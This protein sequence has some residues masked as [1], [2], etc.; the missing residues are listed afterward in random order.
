ML[1][2]GTITAYS[3]LRFRL[4]GVSPR[5]VGLESWTLT[6]VGFESGF[7]RTWTW[8]RTMRTWLQ[9]WFSLPS[10]WGHRIFEVGERIEPFSVG[11]GNGVP[12]RPI[13][14]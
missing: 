4:Y 7:L 6:R 11:G 12:Q 13:G 10:P 14:L 1:S 8:T 2:P 3:Q 9:L 5:V